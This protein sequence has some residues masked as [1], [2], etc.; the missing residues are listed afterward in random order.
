MTNREE[1]LQPEKLKPDNPVTF[2]SSHG[3]YGCF[4]NFSR[5]SIKVDGKRYA[6]SEHYY[7]SQKFKGTRFESVVR[8]AKGPKQAARE[9]RDK[10]KPLRKDWESAKENVMYKALQAKFDQ[11]PDCRETLLS[12][13]DAKIIEA[14]PKDPYWGWGPNRQG[15]N[16]LG[17]LLM[18]LREELRK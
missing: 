2:W 12:T 8:K 16:R 14:S 15:K 10:K 18:R 11:H 13:G 4:S 7:Q 17:F 1:F 3:P 5:H 9:G 6:T